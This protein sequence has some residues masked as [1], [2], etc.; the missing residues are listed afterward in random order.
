M[1]EDL[2]SDTIACRI[3]H[4]YLESLNILILS[5]QVWQVGKRISQIPDF[6]GITLDEVFFINWEPRQSTL[7]RLH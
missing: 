6:A 2:T 1:Q 3:Y 4:S 7:K 5:L